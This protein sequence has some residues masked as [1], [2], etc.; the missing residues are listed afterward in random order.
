MNYLTI[1]RLLSQLRAFWYLIEVASRENND[2]G[3]GYVH[4]LWDRNATILDF[5]R[6]VYNPFTRYEVRSF[7]VRSL[8]VHICGSSRFKF[9][10]LK[11]IFFFLTDRRTRCRTLFHDVPDNKLI[12]TLSEYG[13]L[14]SMLPT[15]MGGCLNF[16]Q[17]E[18][19]E[20]RRAIE[21]EEIS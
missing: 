20:Q 3:S 16:K 11:P 4:I 19:I 15:E 18:W 2:I 12:E 21:M 10:I 9:A 13:I 7:P 6:D 14:G 17:S 8:V 5:D 1:C